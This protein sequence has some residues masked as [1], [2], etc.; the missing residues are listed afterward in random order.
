M[1]VEPFSNQLERWLSE[2]GSKTIGVM[3]EVFSE[4]SFAVTIMVLMFFPAL[5]LPTGGITHVFEGIA[6]LIAAEMVIGFRTLWL[7]P[8]IRQRSL[9]PSITEKA[10]PFMVRRIRWF[11]RISHPRGATFLRRR[12]TVRILGG[13]LICFSVFAAV[14]PPFSGLDTLPALG[15]VV[16]TLAIILEDVVVL[17]IGVAIGSGGALLILSIGAAIAR[18]VS[19]WF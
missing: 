18:L 1:I 11:E 6:I 8:V 7:P 10:L 16:V 9:G 13:I 19:S 2:D 15:A 17:G 4:R 12:S 3:G 5:P 14:A